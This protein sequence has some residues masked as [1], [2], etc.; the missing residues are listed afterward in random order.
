MYGQIKTDNMLNSN[1][2]QKLFDKD[3]EQ[4]PIRKGWNANTWSIPKP[5]RV[6]ARRGRG[7]FQ[8]KNIRDLGTETFCR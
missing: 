3:V 5:E 7:I 1:L 4:I 6:D 2:N 8:E